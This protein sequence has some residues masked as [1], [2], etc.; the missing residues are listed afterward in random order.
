MTGMRFVDVPDP[1][2]IEGGP[3]QVSVI[4]EDGGFQEQ[5]FEIT[6][7]ELCLYEEKTDEKLGVYSLL[8]S[9][10]HT[11]RGSIEMIY[12]EGFRGADALRRASRFLSAN[13]GVS[14]VVLRSIIA[15]EELSKT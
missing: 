14:G 9:V 3:S 1:G 13:L 15:L 4:F 6:K 10:V 2:R 8:T 11:D 5:G 12:D 7:V